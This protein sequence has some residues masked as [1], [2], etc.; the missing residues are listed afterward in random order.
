MAFVIIGEPTQKRKKEK[1]SPKHAFT[2]QF[3]FATTPF[4]DLPLPSVDSPLHGEKSRRGHDTAIGEEE[5]ECRLQRRLDSDRID[6][7]SHQVMRRQEGNGNKTKSKIAAAARKSVNFAAP[8]PFFFLCLSRQRFRRSRINS[9]GLQS[10][11]SQ[12]TSKTRL[13]ITL[14]RRHSA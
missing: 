4:Y 13:F 1:T 6:L 7:T 3:R 5:K 2:F 11:A 9:G 8:D 12:S 10:N 14:P